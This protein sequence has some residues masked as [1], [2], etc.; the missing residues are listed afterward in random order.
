L[1]TRNAIPAIYEL[2][3]FALAGGL[4]SYGI[5]IVDMYRQAGTYRP[6]PKWRQAR[7]FAGH[8]AYK[9]RIGD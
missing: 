2:R 1:A 3:E 8:A 9:I 4:M 7:R 5:N 6:R